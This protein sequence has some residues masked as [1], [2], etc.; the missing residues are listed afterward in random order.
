MSGR[1]EEIVVHHGSVS[2]EVWAKLL[3]LGVYR[4]GDEGSQITIWVYNPKEGLK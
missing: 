1:Y 4:T 2:E 3:P